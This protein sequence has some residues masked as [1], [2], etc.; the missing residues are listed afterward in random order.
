MNGGNEMADMNR[1]GSIS[2]FSQP[3]SSSTRHACI[4]ACVSSGERCRD[5]WRLHF[6]FRGV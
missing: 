1:Y 4:G 5:T 3:L 2:C 6:F